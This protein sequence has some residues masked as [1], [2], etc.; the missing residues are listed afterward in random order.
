MGKKAEMVSNGLIKVPDICVIY[1][2]YQITPKRDFG[3]TPFLSAS[4][5]CQKGY[6]ICDDYCNVMPGATWAASVL[7]AKAM[8]D[9]WI[10][11]NFDNNKFWELL[12]ERQGLAEWEEV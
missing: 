6:V 12:R 1:Q 2:G 11:A 4:G 5:E 8:I 9:C 10:E 3:N 7:E